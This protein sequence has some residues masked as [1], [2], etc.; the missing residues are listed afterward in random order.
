MVGVYIIRHV[1]SG[2]C[3]VGSSKNIQVRWNKH[4]EDLRKGKHHSPT[5][6]RA[7][8]K[9][10]ETAFLFEVVEETTIEQLRT[11]EALWL[12]KLR[13]FYNSM[14]AQNTQL[15]EHGPSTRKLMSESQLRRFA[16]ER[17][18]GGRKL[19][20]EQKAKIAASHIGIRPSAATRAKMSASAKR[21]GGRPMPRHAVERIAASNRGRKRSEETKRRLS[22][23]HKGYKMPTEQRAKISQSLRGRVVTEET[24]KKLSLRNGEAL[25]KLV[26]TR[27]GKSL[28]IEHR[29][30]ISAGHR[31][32]AIQE[33]LGEKFKQRDFPD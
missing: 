12:S 14:T 31:R 8:N 10:S 3:Y 15:I 27:R 32:R 16:R 26:E 13:P 5:L 11:A 17:V 7:W 4:R 25:R 6:Q 30:R 20:P 19:S 1:E 24:R 2:R 21:R 29:A 18:R 33:L 22:E 28:S 9:Y 23:A